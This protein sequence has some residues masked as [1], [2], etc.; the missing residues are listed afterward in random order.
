LLLCHRSCA[1]AVDFTVPVVSFCPHFFLFDV[2]SI[3]GCFLRKLSSCLF[4]T[5]VR[6]ESVS[7]F[8]SPPHSGPFFGRLVDSMMVATMMTTQPRDP[9]HCGCPVF[10]GHTA[11]VPRRASRSEKRVCGMDATRSSLSPSLSLRRRGAQSD[12]RARAAAERDARGSVRAPAPSNRAG[13]SCPRAPRTAPPPITGG[14]VPGMHILCALCR[15]VG[16]MTET[17][18][19]MHSTFPHFS[20]HFVSRFSFLFVVVVAL[21]R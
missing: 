10:S 9:V 7:T 4:C 21:A 5:C 15:P 18:Q 13:S 6:V 3:T 17:Q 14:T 19:T 8:L 20:S 16:A 11:A 12:R 2:S 1:R